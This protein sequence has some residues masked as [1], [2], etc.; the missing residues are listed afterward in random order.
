[1]VPSRPKLAVLQARK[2][3]VQPQMSA[4][5]PDSK[6][7]KELRRRPHLR[8]WMHYRRPE[9][10][11]QLQQNSRVPRVLRRAPQLPF[12][13][14]ASREARCLVLSRHTTPPDPHKL[15]GVH[16]PSAAMARDYRATPGKQPLRAHARANFA[17]GSKGNPVLSSDYGNAAAE[18][19]LRFPEGVRKTQEDCGSAEQKKRGRPENL[20]LLNQWFTLALLPRGSDVPLHREAKR[21][22]RSIIRRDVGLA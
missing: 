13:P 11:A 7:P 9:G 16:P 21:V 18:R 6:L 19:Q 2:P 22:H 8:R 10:S 12:G 4:G 20:P 14:A 17:V 5:R 3:Q 15:D 1:M